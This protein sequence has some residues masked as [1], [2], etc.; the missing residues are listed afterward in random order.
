MEF[1][2]NGADVVR[3]VVPPRVRVEQRVLVLED[4][5]AAPF[6][7]LTHPRAGQ[8]RPSIF[9]R[10]IGL[11]LESELRPIHERGPIQHVMRVQY[12]E[13]SGAAELGV[14][15]GAVIVPPGGGVHHAARR[16][17]WLVDGA[18][19]VVG[20]LVVDHFP[21]HRIGPRVGEVGQLRITIHPGDEL[22]RAAVFVR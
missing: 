7:E 1:V 21:E 18:Q 2:G 16:L 9:H 12:G 20:S 6:S 15:G 22:H 3:A 8:S 11:V 5:S 13:S 4:A 17:V 10:L 14:V 19:C